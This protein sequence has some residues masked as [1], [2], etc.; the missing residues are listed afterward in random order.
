MYYSILPLNYGRIHSSQSHPAFS[1]LHVW[2]RSVHPR[3]MLNT[4][5]T[6]WNSIFFSRFGRDGIFPISLA[7]SYRLQPWT[8]RVQIC[9][10]LS[11]FLLFYVLL[12]HETCVLVSLFLLDC[13]FLRTVMKIILVITTTT[14]SYHIPA[15]WEHITPFQQPSEDLFHFQMWLNNVPKASTQEW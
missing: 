11:Y 13:K 6:Y 12:E 9:S 7:T 2:I 15:L 14:S 1:Y 10:S 5:F 8:S 3:V 4:V